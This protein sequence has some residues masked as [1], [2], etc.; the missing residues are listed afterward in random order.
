M[1]TIGIIGLLA[2]I[3]LFPN[4]WARTGSYGINETTSP[5]NVAV[6]NGKLVLCRT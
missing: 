2:S 6:I 5:K 3:L 4:V 1:V